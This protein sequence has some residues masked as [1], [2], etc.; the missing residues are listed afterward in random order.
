MTFF[1][2]A[3]VHASVNNAAFIEIACDV[4]GNMAFH[5]ERAKQIQMARTQVKWQLCVCCGYGASACAKAGAQVCV[6]V[7]MET[8]LLLQQWGISMGATASSADGSAARRLASSLVKISLHSDAAALLRVTSQWEGICRQQS[9]MR[10]A[11]GNCRH[12]APCFQ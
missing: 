10:L 8:H 9:T 1:R 12:T 2:C 3:D 5:T 7:P 6:R 11:Y 4:T